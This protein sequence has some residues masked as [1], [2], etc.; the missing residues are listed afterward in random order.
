MKMFNKDAIAP[1][2]TENE[3]LRNENIKL[4]R[5][6]QEYKDCMVNR[7]PD[8]KVGEYCSSCQ[9]S[10]TLMEHS[11]TGQ[12]ITVVVCIKGRMCKN[13]KAKGE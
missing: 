1:L 10:K 2:K 9:F 4:K 12:L 11:Y 13:Y 5:M 3:I 7:P 8:C 6:I